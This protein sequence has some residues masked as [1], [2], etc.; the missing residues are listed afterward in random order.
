MHSAI[1][2]RTR[3]LVDADDIR[4]GRHGAYL[5]PCC[6]G[7]VHYQRSI[8]IS[9][10][11]LFVHYPHEGTTDC[12]N[13]YPWQGI[14]PSAQSVT[15]ARPMPAVEDTPDELGLCLEDF[16][17]WALYLRLPEMT[18]SELGTVSLRSLTKAFVEIDSAGARNRLPAIELKPGVGSARVVVPPTTIPYKVTTTGAWPATIRQGRWQT[19]SRGL[20]VRGTLF[21]FRHGEWVRLRESSPVELGEELRVVADQRNAPPAECRPA[22]TKTVSLRGQTW[23]MWRVTLPAVESRQL[24]RWLESLGTEAVEPAWE[25]RFASIP[26]AIEEQTP[27]FGRSEPLIVRIR[28]LHRGGRAD[29]S[30]S[31]GST[32]STESFSTPPGSDK[33]FIGFAVPWPGSNK[34]LVAYDDRST[35]R[36]E[37]KESEELSKIR[38]ALRILP[39]LVVQIGATVVKA[40]DEPVEIT[41]PS[42]SEELPVVTME[43]DFDDIRVNMT[44]AGPARGTTPARGS[45]EGLSPDIVVRRLKELLENRQ[46]RE[47]RIEDRKS[48]RLNSS[49]LG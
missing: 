18:S 6:G 9:P 43:P 40:W 34:L 12:E 26:S 21:R 2:A 16:D 41:V 4:V 27:V 42:R 15:T 45:D 28:A 29:V 33:A 23:R 19:T 14:Y 46:S 17:L 24:A 5:C 11:P 25:V 3:K 31:A 1:D 20:N 38:V 10:D 47:I 36:F 48:T 30:L 22:A 44:W 7:R 49:H 35:L 39:Q 8:G 37:T 13:Y 32:R